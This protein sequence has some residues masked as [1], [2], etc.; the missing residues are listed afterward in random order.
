[1]KRSKSNFQR[2]QLESVAEPSSLQLMELIKLSAHARTI[3]ELTFCS[4]HS[5]YNY[6]LGFLKT[7]LKIFVT[8]NSSHCF[9]LISRVSSE[10][11]SMR[12]RTVE[13]V[14]LTIVRKPSVLPKDAIIL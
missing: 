14:S 8:Y 7:L 9:F 1:M 5:Q 10:L 12:D 2:L 4:L 13:H 3:R 11:T 6:S